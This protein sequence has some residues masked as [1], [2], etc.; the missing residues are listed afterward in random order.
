MR[1]RFFSRG[2]LFLFL[3]AALFLFPIFS[4]AAQSSDVQISISAIVGTPTPPAPPTPTPPPLPPGPGEIFIPPQGEIIFQ[5]RAYPSAFITIF[6]DGQVV[7]TF[8][9]EPSGLFKKQLTLQ[10][11][12]YNFGIYAEDTEGRKSVALNFMTSVLKENLTTVSGIFIPPTIAVAPDR[13]LQG[14]KINILGQVFPESQVEIFIM[15][16]KIEKKTSAGNNGKWSFELN[17]ASLKPG[18]YK[19]SARGIFGDGEQSR[20]SQGLGFSV[21]SPVPKQCQGPDLNFDGKVDIVDFSILLYFWKQTNP[22]NVCAD[23]NANG[24][25]DIFDFSIMMWGWTG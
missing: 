13:L 15:P 11:G 4:R 12:T 20:F 25:V 1:N 19:V 18:E 23:I 22:S 16:E 9:A 24:I 17:T 5:G 21:L 7:A 2:F 6:K 10:G 3:G 14:Q 8:F